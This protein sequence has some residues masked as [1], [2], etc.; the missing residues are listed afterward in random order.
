MVLD[1]E[2]EPILEDVPVG[3]GRLPGLP[4]LPRHEQAGRLR[5]QAS[6]QAD[7]PPG[8]F[9]QELLVDAGTVIEALQVRVG[10]QPE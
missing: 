7:Q 3:A 10:D 2:V 6:G 4:L 8:P 9:G 5:G 1:L